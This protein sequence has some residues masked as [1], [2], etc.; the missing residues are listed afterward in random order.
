MRVLLGSRLG[1][2]VEKELESGKVALLPP[3]GGFIRL[4]YENS[5]EIEIRVNGKSTCKPKDNEIKCET[6]QNGRFF[7]EITTLGEERKLSY[8]LRED[9]N[10]MPRKELRAS[11][12]DFK[13]QVVNIAEK[14][15]ELTYTKLHTAIENGSLSLF[16]LIDPKTDEA[17]GWLLDEIELTLPFLS[18]VCS[19]PRKH[20]HLE[21]AVRPVDIVT[22]TGQAAL[23]HLAAHSEHWETQTFNGLRPARLLAQIYE[24]DLKLYENRFVKTLIDRLITHVAEIRKLVELALGQSENTLDWNELLSD[25]AANYY[26][27]GFARTLLSGIDL[28]KVPSQNDYARSIRERILSIYSTLLR[29]KSTPF[30]QVIC[31]TPPVT[32]PIYCT[33]ILGMDPV[34][35]PL[36]RLW[37][38]LDQKEQLIEKAIS[39]EPPVENRS[40]YN[41]YCQ[42][43]ILAALKFAGFESL[44]GDSQ[45]VGKCKTVRNLEIYGA[46]KRGDWVVNVSKDDSLGRP[47]I[48][49]ITFKRYF[50]ER[51]PLDHEITPP[52][53]L[54]P[55]VE[56]K[57]KIENLE[58]ILQEK[59]SRDEQNELSK[60]IKTTDSRDLSAE[61]QQAKHKKEQKWA[62]F[63]NEIS[64]KVK[65]PE[66]FILNLIPIFTELGQEINDIDSHTA[67]LLDAAYSNTS[68]K[69][70][71][72]SFI[73]IPVSPRL[74]NSAAPPKILRRV[75]NFGDNFSE[76]DAV[77]WK[78][79]KAGLLPISPDQLN[80]LTRLIR[81]INTYTVGYDIAHNIEL[82]K[83]PV[84][85]NA[86]GGNQRKC[87]KCGTEWYQNVC[88]NCG[89]KYAFLRPKRK[90]SSIDLKEGFY[91]SWMEKLENLTGE[92]AISS[93]CEAA[94]AEP[95][96]RFPICP[97]CGHCRETEKHS[98]RCPRCKNWC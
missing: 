90:P 97:N 57:A 42:I 12:S 82:S 43:M 48:I 4:D 17:N 85:F 31:Q 73:L 1:G 32:P 34:Y 88:T 78:G 70:I 9:T 55:S 61:E 33:N 86:V 36:Y 47:I 37:Q 56:G 63:I 93:F 91:T 35:H 2:K 96:L 65:D 92:T 21:E 60:L 14:S 44:K 19:R 18:R 74:V 11:L 66:E 27:S 13:R 94:S 98:G 7:L 71:A 40:S 28:T 83:C 67:S 69:N 50:P 24:D 87:R 81:L 52:S 95:R 54:P 77:R 38:L 64:N 30:Y 39:K 53:S 49:K 76:N 22:R 41:Y 29:Y 26:S 25:Q 20:L 5:H 8:D 46:Y 75:I 89:E 23:K 45:I 10:L 68:Q 79:R 15:Q 58:L 62:Q 3:Q 59:L 72:S 80:S 51:F 16:K 6:D 84:C